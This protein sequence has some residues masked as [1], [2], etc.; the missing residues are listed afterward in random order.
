MIP[1]D[2]APAPSVLKVGGREL[3]PGPGLDS[4]VAT[5]GALRS[6]GRQLLLVHGG[7]E[8]VTDRA[9]ALGLRTTRERGQ[10]L[11][12]LPMLEV[13]VEVLAG[14]VNS[15]LVAALGRAG[16][17][18][19]GLTG[20]SERILLVAP[21]GTPPGALGRVGT[22]RQVRARP[23]LRLWE[24]GVL[25]VLA[26]I[27]VDRTGNLYNVNADL[28][29]AAVAAALRSELW[30][31]T[32]VEGVQD[33]TGAVQSRLTPAGA[34]E[35]LRRGAANHGMIPK[36]EAAELAARKGARGVWI[37]SLSGLSPTGPRSGHGTQ[38]L[39]EVRAGSSPPILRVPA[40]GGRR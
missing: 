8:E 14:R 39:P 31:V 27:G 1:N 35:L 37:G 23:L 15:R 13:V 32:D 4:L 9:E 12:S 17:E 24:E 2:P 19:H 5:V 6:S 29:A 40:P 16:I 25:P 7:G 21:A 34:S 20:A 18:A 26:P 30:L 22:P 33:A 28:A 36:L 10:R 11:T 38:F 3:L